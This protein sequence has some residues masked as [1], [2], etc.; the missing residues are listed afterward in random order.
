MHV[1]IDVLPSRLSEGTQKKF[2]F[3][4]RWLIILFCLTAMVIGGSRLVYITYV[5]D[6]KSAALQLPLAVVYM[7]IPISGILIIYYK[8]SDILKKD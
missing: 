5:L 1:A 6:Q 8:I 2:K 3:I 4:V 7:V